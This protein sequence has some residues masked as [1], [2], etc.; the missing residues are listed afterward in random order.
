M[1]F[2]SARPI[3]F[4][5]FAAALALAAC[6]SAGDNAATWKAGALAAREA[7]HQ[8][9]KINAKA[10]TPPR[11][12]DPQ[13]AK[14]LGSLFDIPILPD[15]MSARS[16]GSIR[17]WL[18]SVLLVG[19]T[20]LGA[21]TSW[22]TDPQGPPILFSSENVGT[23]APEMG[24]YYDATLQL[25]N[26]LD[27]AVSDGERQKHGRMTAD[28]WLLASNIA[29]ETVQLLIATLAAMTL[30]RMTDDWRGKRMYALQRVA[31]SAG[32]LLSHQQRRLVR[33]AIEKAQDVTGSQPL[34]DQLARLSLWFRDPIKA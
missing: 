21:S 27:D 18:D 31:P 33:E 25:I 28:E 23:Y 2:M 32:S 16:I 3:C 19:A 29:D 20:Y 4:L 9:M 14:L 6:H 7:A 5:G 15:D 13:A 11:Q 17:G 22:R 8:I 24:R 30:P 26:A 10:G 1:R 34:K 12:T